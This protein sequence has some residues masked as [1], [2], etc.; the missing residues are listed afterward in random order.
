MLR[1]CL[2]FFVDR[3]WLPH[4]LSSQILFFVG[5]SVLLISLFFGSFF[6]IYSLHRSRALID[7]QM[8]FVTKNVSSVAANHVLTSDVLALEEILLLNASFSY[9]ESITIL[10]TNYKTLLKVLKSKQGSRIVYEISQQK[11]MVL[12]QPLAV[13][14]VAG[15]EKKEPA[16]WLLPQNDLIIWHQMGDASAVGYVGVEYSLDQLNETTASLL[17]ITFLAV[18]FTSILV[19]VLLWL[20]MRVPM[21][22]LQEITAFAT[23]SEI[24][25][26][27]QLPV[28]QKTHEIYELS[29]ALNQFSI[30][31]RSHERNLLDRMAQN[32][33]ILDNLA[34][35]IVVTESN[36]E[37]RS[38]NFALT[39][40]FG[41][42]EI[43]LVG[44]NIAILMPAPI[45]DQHDGHMAN[46]GLTGRS[47]IIGV[48]REVE[49]KRKDGTVFPADLAI[50]KC[51]DKD[52][53][54]F[55]GVLRDIS[56]RKKLDRLKSEFVSTVSHE[57][58]T[59][60]TS[61]HGSLKLVVAGVTGELNPEAKRM[62]CLAQKNSE[63]L[64]LLINDLLD[65]EK[66]VAGKMDMKISRVD[67]VSVLNQSIADNTPY[68]DK[69]EV[70]LQLQ[71][72]PEA[73]Y[74]SGDAARIA[75]VFANLLS[76]AAKFSG[77]SKV[78]DVRVIS[79]PDSTTIEVEDH[80]DGIA[81]DFQD[82]IFSAFAQASSGNTRQQGG[83]GL[84]LKISK[85]LVEAMGGEIGFRTQQGVGTV[86]WFSLKNA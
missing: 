81:A 79:N 40:I 60:L 68:A 9:V 74:V 44:K 13:E 2:S 4:R 18:G 12:D 72:S 1:K 62:V 61:I 75:Q 77:S 73:A 10:D 80:G 49:A 19:M 53:I 55:I 48:G 31:I 58:R 86:F 11:P 16:S 30:M 35:G 14:V 6:T 28:Y 8:L 21:R 85:V 15:S 7:D 41:Y 65:M 26:G 64:I 43:E 5:A 69:Y 83:T 20:W 27:R 50:S 33:A 57:L 23:V 17:A 22:F 76:N 36:G 56:E 32:Q 46:Y 54:I 67:I 3:R 82:K 51:R 47:K 59:P 66:L 84:G 37:I 63:R 78:V 34:D 42:E 38:C 39:K 24:R 25:S 52:D 71:T 70:A 45:A 29:R